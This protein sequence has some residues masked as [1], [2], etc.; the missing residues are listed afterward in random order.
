MTKNKDD[1]LDPKNV[2][3]PSSEECEADFDESVCSAEFVDGCIESV[4]EQNDRT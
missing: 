1:I 4:K 3:T 2:V